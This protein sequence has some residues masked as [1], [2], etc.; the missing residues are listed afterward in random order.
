ML[1]RVWRAPIG[2]LVATLRFRVMLKTEHQRLMMEA[3]STLLCQVLP[4]VP[5]RSP[6]EYHH[7]SIERRE[8][9][10][11]QSNIST[12]TIQHVNENRRPVVV[13]QGDDVRKQVL[14]GMIARKAKS[15]TPSL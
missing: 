2:K 15:H 13:Y 6:L 7:T 5:R 3:R 12:G 14:S 4:Q 1:T 9:N 8:G 11:A 10:H